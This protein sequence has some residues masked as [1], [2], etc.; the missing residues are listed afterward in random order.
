MTNETAQNDI[1][2]ED[3]LMNTN[4]PVDTTLELTITT[5]P[6]LAGLPR[7]QA[8]SKQSGEQCRRVAT[9]GHRVCKS[10]GSGSPQARRAAALRLSDLVT[11][12]IAT[13][14]RVLT[15]PNAKNADKIK[16]SE[17]ILDRAGHPRTTRAERISGEDAKQILFEKLLALRN[18]SRGEEDD[19]T[20]E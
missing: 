16:A 13:F 7:C 6:N 3:D 14:A 8:R 15:D 9:P 1:D 12:A 19:E 17:A 2:Q 11:P 18:A 5:P 20:D 10:H 4:D